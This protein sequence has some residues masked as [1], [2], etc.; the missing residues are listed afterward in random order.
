M[1]EL[2]EGQILKDVNKWIPYW[3]KKRL[4]YGSF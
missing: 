1:T 4:G 3:L 2:N